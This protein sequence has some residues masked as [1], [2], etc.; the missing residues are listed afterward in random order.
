MSYG[1]VYNQ[2]LSL[3]SV[4]VALRH[5]PKD[6]Y[7]DINDFYDLEYILICEIENRNST[8]QTKHCTMLN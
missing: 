8:P 3:S 6:K 5:Y 7:L 2:T 4:V 1:G